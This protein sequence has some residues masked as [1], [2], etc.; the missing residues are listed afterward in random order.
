MAKK[1]MVIDN[2]IQQKKDK[3]ANERKRKYEEVQ[4]E[5]NNGLPLHQLSITQLKSLCLHKKNKD[6]K[7]LISKLKRDELVLLWMSWKSR[8]DPVNISTSSQVGVD[9]ISGT[10]VEVDCDKEECHNINCNENTTILE[11]AILLV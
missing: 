5:L 2:A 7:V 4:K 11:P 9:L 1:K 8:S 10:S 6:D 3:M